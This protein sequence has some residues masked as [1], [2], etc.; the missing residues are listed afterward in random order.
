MPEFYQCLLDPLILSQ[1]QKEFHHR[2]HCLILL[3]MLEDGQP[4]SHFDHDVPIMTVP[5][6]TEE[7]GGGVNLHL[8]LK[9]STTHSAFIN[10]QF[11]IEGM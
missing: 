9:K 5:E 11:G 1:H 10:L 2:E 3:E 6:V 8:F 7:Q 4:C